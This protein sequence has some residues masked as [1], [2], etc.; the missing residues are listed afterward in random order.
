MNRK[1]VTIIKDPTDEEKVNIVKSIYKNI[2]NL[3]K[4]IKL[5][6]EE[7]LDNNIVLY[8][9]M[10]YECRIE[11]VLD[12]LF[13]EKF[14][15]EIIV[16]IDD[17]LKGKISIDDTDKAFEFN[18]LRDLELSDIAESFFPESLMLVT[19]LT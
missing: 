2:G 1:N 10:N 4:K 16:N 3:K 7:C 8:K 14:G 9:G 5:P 11:I 13:S 19:M 17:S 6:G 12:E 18:Y 15:C